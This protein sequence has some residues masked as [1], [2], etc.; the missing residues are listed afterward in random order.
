MADD[1]YSYDDG[2]DGQNVDDSQ[3]LREVR[4]RLKESDKVRKAAEKERDAA[5]AELTA[6]RGQVRESNA[7]T[8]ADKLGMTEKQLGLYLKANPDADVTEDGLK[9]FAEE[10]GML[11]PKPDDSAPKTSTAEE[12][13]AS[14]GIPF[15]PMQ[16]GASAPG[17]KPGLDEFRAMYKRN[18]Q[19]AEQAAL[20]G[21][22]EFDARVVP[23]GPG[24]AIEE[25]TL[26]PDS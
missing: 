2:D 6:L 12:R 7:R 19:A 4:S 17:P 20:R 15:V 24:W 25:P 18:P 26:F 9:G 23:H 5:Q 8:L 1:D 21:E 14:S 11:A 22:F 10:Y 13:L 16:G 3:P